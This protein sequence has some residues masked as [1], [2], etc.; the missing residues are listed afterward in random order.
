MA[1]HQQS[2]LSINAGLAAIEKPNDYKDES[3]VDS[4]CIPEVS[5]DDVRVGGILGKGSFNKIKAVT[6]RSSKHRKDKQK[7][8][9]KF[10]RNSI[11]EKDIFPAAAEDLAIEGQLLSYLRHEN[12]ITLHAQGCRSDAN[13]HNSRHFLI[14]E[15]LY[16]TLDEKIYDWRYENDG[17]MPFVIKNEEQ[18]TICDRIRNVALPVARALEYLHSQHIVFRDLKPSNI[19]F[20]RNGTVKLFDFG[21]ARVVK[22]D[23]RMTGRVGS[24]LYMP[25]EVV[26]SKH[27]GLPVDV[28]AFSLILWEVITLDI[29]F[30]G[31]KRAELEQKVTNQ[32]LRPEVNKNCGSVQLQQLLKN[33]WSESPESR[34]NFSTIRKALEDEKKFDNKVIAS[35]I[36]SEKEAFSARSSGS[37]CLHSSTTGN[38]PSLKCKKLNN[39]LS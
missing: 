20:S 9:V 14:L 21:L 4:T 38:Q 8:S 1:L 26:Q 22:H 31:M 16:D 29:P 30:E 18:T 27:Y 15:R 10:L 23:R 33:G 34:P 7:Y 37:C 17:T 19:G 35:M 28:Y 39:S 6:F 5:W 11:I 13:D 25:K 32:G 2:D 12:I 24:P 3:N 36:S